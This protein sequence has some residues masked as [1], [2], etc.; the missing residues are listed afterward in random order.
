MSDQTEPRDEGIS[1]DE[2]SELERLRDENGALRRYF[3]QEI[4][5]LVKLRDRLLARAE[6]AEAALR[7]VMEILKARHDVERNQTDQ[8]VHG[9]H[10]TS[11]DYPNILSISGLKEPKSELNQSPTE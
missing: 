3:E 5:T 2:V 11:L 1:S 6:T 10:L 8:M 4:D 9:V 7:K